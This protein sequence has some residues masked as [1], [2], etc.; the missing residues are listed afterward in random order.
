MKLIIRR[1]IQESTTI[2]PEQRAG[3]KLAWAAVRF[4]LPPQRRN[5]PVKCVLDIGPRKP[6]GADGCHRKEH[7]P[8]CKQPR[9]PPPFFSRLTCTSLLS[10]KNRHLTRP[11]AVAGRSP[12]RD[13]ATITAATASASSI[14]D[15]PGVTTPARSSSPRRC[16]ATTITR[17]NRWISS[18][19]S[20]TPAFRR[21]TA[22]RTHG[23]PQAIFDLLRTDRNHDKN[24]VFSLRLRKKNNNI[25]IIWVL[26]VIF[27]NGNE[28]IKPNMTLFDKQKLTEMVLYIL[29]KTNGLDYYHV[30]KIIYFANIA[31]LSRCGL[32]ITTDDFCAL[33]DGPVPSILY[34]SIKKVGKAVRNM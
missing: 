20:D 2:H 16:R 29:N 21:A 33:Q 15:L 11:A 6:Q 4:R 28:I 13:P 34:D 9:H 30:F 10:W 5:G 27:A 14:E 18:S 7:Q 22:L 19:G 25:I 1:K 24:V 32:R 3:V 31:H 12:N 23:R 26:H 8:Q 17:W